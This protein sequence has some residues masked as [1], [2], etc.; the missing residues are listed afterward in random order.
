M[1]FL[2]NMTKSADVL[3]CPDRHDDIEVSLKHD[4]DRQSEIAPDN[5]FTFTM[6]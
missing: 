5:G 1:L 3:D 6:S 4:A 2:G